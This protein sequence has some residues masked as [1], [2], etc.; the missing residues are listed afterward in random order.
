LPSQDYGGYVTVRNGSQQ[1]VFTIKISIAKTNLGDNDVYL[2]VA[3]LEYMVTFSTERKALNLQLFKDYQ[4]CR[5]V[6][7]RNRLVMLNLGCVRKEAY[8]WARQSSESYEDLLQVGSMGLIR[9]IERFDLSQG[10]ALTSFAVPYIQGEIRHHLRDRQ[11]LIRVPRSWQS[12]QYQSSQVTQRFQTQQHRAPT[13]AEMSRALQ[14]SL[15][16]WQAVKLAKLLPL[17]LQQPV[18]GSDRTTEYRF[19]QDLLPDPFEP[20]QQEE[21]LCLYQLLLQIETPTRSVLEFVFL[22]DLTQKETAARLG[23]SIVTVARRVKK[24][25]KLLR[26]LLAEKAV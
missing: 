26:H 13:D 17:S 5:S 24:G 10:C 16:E 4:Q 25:L 1:Q 3:F 22:H 2:L 20:Q 12:L 9:A 23:I 14:I 8:R 18:R 11:T 19:L 6:E 21:L 15:A 7:I